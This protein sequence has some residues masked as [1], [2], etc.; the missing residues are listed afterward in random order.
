MSSVAAI[1][2]G[3]NSV[4]LLIV[5]PG[6][7]EAAREMHI[8]R[9]AEGVDQSGRLA[10]AAMGRTLEVLEQYAALMRRFDVQRDR[11]ERG[12]GRRKPRAVL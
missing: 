1:D 4:R 2:M 3:S 12:A 8:T 11:Y 9:L 10:E 7:A 6:G 5:E